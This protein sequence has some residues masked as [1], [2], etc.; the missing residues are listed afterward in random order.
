MIGEDAPETQLYSGNYPSKARFWRP[1][2][3]IYSILFIGIIAAYT[4]LSNTR[5]GHE[6]DGEIPI[7]IEEA[8]R[9]YDLAEERRRE[10]DERHEQRMLKHKIDEVNKNAEYVRK[11]GFSKP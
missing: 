9:R 3:T 4:I 7:S 6:G 2:P 1:G 11:Y 5:E 10:A 8:N